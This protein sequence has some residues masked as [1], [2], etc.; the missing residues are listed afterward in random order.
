MGR[1]RS[2]AWQ[3]TL[4]TLLG[5]V[6]S[7]GLGLL[8]NAIDP[9]WTKNHWW[10][11]ALPVA[12]AIVVTLIR[13]G[14]NGKQLDTIVN[15][16]AVTS[17][18]D[19]VLH[20]FAVTASGTVIRRRYREGGSWT[21]WEDHGFPK[22][23]AHDVAA[24][25]PAHGR[26]ETYVADRDGVIWGR[27]YGA[28]GWSSWSQVPGDGRVGPVAALDVMSGWPGHRE[29]YAVGQNGKLGHTWQRDGEAWSRWASAHRDGCRDVALSVPS[30]GQMECFVLDRDGQLWH[31]WYVDQHWSEWWSL[32]QPPDRTP[33]IALSALNSRTNH[34]EVY[35]VG[36]SG[37][38][39]HRW[40]WQGNDWDRW[41]PM[42]SPP[43]RLIDV[44]AGTT[45][46][47]HY[48]VL[49]AGA[50]GDIWRRTYSP[51]TDWS[52]WQRV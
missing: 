48:E 42:P 47:S 12:A 21:D 46:A 38:F 16:V 26:L 51:Q 4:L 37:D 40:H 50:E 24:V 10:I 8:A 30:P 13:Q 45:S 27:R 32:E 18:G 14:G 36:S 5:L 28:N 17:H 23:T 3:S 33:S 6:I 52:S 2:K 15:R 44:A 7:T 9:H 49:A 41:Y 34:Q 39:A 29:I 11:V 22:A 35:V 19:G 20:L 31:R 43:D 25:A 1:A